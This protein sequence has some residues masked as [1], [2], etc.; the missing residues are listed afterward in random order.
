MTTPTAIRPDA[1]TG[2]DTTQAAAPRSAVLPVLLIG[3]G[4]VVA[5]GSMLP[6]LSVSVNP[7]L[8]PSI[9]T[10][11]LTSIRGIDVREGVT[12][13]VFGLGI[14]TLGA[15]ASVLTR[16]RRP[17]LIAALLCAA[18]ALLLS[19]VDLVYI[20]RQQR[21]VRNGLPA[22]IS[23]SS[24]GVGLWMS[25]L[26]SATAIAVSGL[27]IAAHISHARK[28]R[29]SDESSH[30]KPDSAVTVAGRKLR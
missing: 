13:L 28:G 22:W 30:R 8:P 6:W 2:P 29:S 5:L 17:L 25:V 14:G 12:T 1:A 15:L 26:A 27:A 7:D 11:G 9:D 3:L 19:A 18:C 24:V 10:S 21:P 23:D 16:P 20:G 4:T